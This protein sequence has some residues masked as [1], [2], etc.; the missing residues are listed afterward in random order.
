MF[1]K[2]DIFSKN[3]IIV[4]AGTSLVN[5]FNLLY[6][7]LIAHKLNPSDFAAFN[8]LLAI[9]VLISSPLGTFAVVVAKY[10]A[11]FN[12]RGEDNKV[13]F[14]LS[15]LFKKSFILAIF[16]FLIFWFAS[17]CLINILK[18]PSVFCGYIL[19]A[20]LASAWLT[21]VFLGGIQGLELFGW[22]VTG[23]VLSGALKL[24]LAFILILLG[25]NAAGA[26]GALLISNI[27][28]IALFYFPLRRF[29]SLKIFPEEA[30]YRG[31][32][33]YLFPVA[34]SCFCFTAL[35][36]SD[37]LLVRYFFTPFESGIYSLAQMVGK[38]FLFLPGAI[39]IVMFPRMSGL[40]A[41]NLNTF[42]TLK[43]SFLYV[44]G[45]CFIAGI[46]YN[47]FPAFVLKVVSG[48]IFPE[49]IILGRLFSVSMSIFA[50]SWLLI[51]YFLSI[52]DFR[53]IKY[54]VLSALSQNLVIICFHPSLIWV[55]V[56][57]CVN[58]A[59]LFLMLFQA[60]YKKLT[61]PI[62]A[63]AQ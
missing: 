8:S 35:V 25:Y 59:L 44:A 27:I 42:V 47:F 19:A 32:F 58:S 6:Q 21:P 23:S 62:G 22:F 33:A 51:T 49:S 45:L 55:G 14:L 63:V 48:K 26:L 29:I 3:I 10:C 54:L 7:L 38:I 56:I 37:M 2:I 39:S 46:F 31:M 5:F 13:R 60:C 4:F 36:N 15:D 50:L 11:E 20:L 40:K 41:K 61:Q 1:K 17:N 12:A 9:F 52:N 53:F 57:L 34:I 24:G 28:S 16:T 30:C 18:I 43:I